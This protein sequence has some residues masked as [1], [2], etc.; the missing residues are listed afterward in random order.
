MTGVETCKELS[1]SQ[2]LLDSP[3]TGRYNPLHDAGVVQW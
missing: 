1:S 2:Y 3:M